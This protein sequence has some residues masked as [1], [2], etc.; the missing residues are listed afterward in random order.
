MG[1]QSLQKLIHSLIHSFAWLECPDKDVWLSLGDYKK[2]ETCAQ[3]HF[4]P[5]QAL[6]YTATHHGGDSDKDLECPII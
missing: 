4:G 2:K 5:P 1:P 6:T 3:N